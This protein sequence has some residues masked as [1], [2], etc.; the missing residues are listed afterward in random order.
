MALV[1]AG[2]VTTR[3]HRKLLG[4]YR[5]LERTHTQRVEALSRENTILHEHKLELEKENAI[6]GNEIESLR[7]QC[8]AEKANFAAFQERTRQKIRSLKEQAANVERRSSRHIREINQRN[9][10]TVDSLI[11]QIDTLAARLSAFQ[12]KCSRTVQALKDSTAKDRFAY[13]KELYALERIKEEL[14][15][16]LRDKERAL[17]QLK[18]RLD[19]QSSP[20][21]RPGHGKRADDA[22]E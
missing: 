9:S 11:Q 1:F 5:E 18:D 19:Q 2:C 14:F 15:G 7:S 22:S 4:D 6:L 21:K 10:R 16:K 17:Q 3:S 20:E 12:K 13:E 8:A